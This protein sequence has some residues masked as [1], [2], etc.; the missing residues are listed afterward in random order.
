MGVL[1]RAPR[2]WIVVFLLSWMRICSKSSLTW[3]RWLRVFLWI[4]IPIQRGLLILT[5]MSKFYLQMPLFLNWFEK[6]GEFIPE[7][8]LMGFEKV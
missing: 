5:R 8:Q 4:N 6:V 1:K 7:K 2:C 3:K